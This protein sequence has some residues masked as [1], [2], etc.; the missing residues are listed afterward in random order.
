MASAPELPDLNLPQR[1][2]LKSRSAPVAEISSL[3]SPQASHSW[4]GQAE[5]AVPETP[6]PSGSLTGVS[7]QPSSGQRWAGWL[8]LGWQHCLPGG[9][10]AGGLQSMLLLCQ[11]VGGMGA[12][13]VPWGAPGGSGPEAGCSC[14][15]PAAAVPFP[16]LQVMLLEQTGQAARLSA[17][18]TA[19]S[20]PALPA[21]PSCI[22][23]GVGHG[24]TV[25]P[26]LR[27]SG[28]MHCC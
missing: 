4:Q 13:T 20:Q 5:P 10:L 28:V 24:G 19:T 6:H 2:W 15:G 18:G 27:G 26:V 17:P 11:S 22:L 25:F 1:F 14:S 16:P 7:A 8:A 12:P 23:Q 21:F 3:L 9:E